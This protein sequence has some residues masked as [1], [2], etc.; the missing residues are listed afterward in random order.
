MKFIHF[1]IVPAL[2]I[3]VTSCS[4]VSVDADYDDHIAFSEYKTFGYYKDG[5][6][7]VQISDLDK[8]RIL[9]AI[10]YQLNAKGLIRSN[11]PDILVNIFTKTREEISVNQFNAGWGYGWGFGWNP[12]MWNPNVM[13]TTTTITE[14]F[15]YIDLIDAKKNELVWQGVGRG[16]IDTSMK[17]RERTINEFVYKIIAQYPPKIKKK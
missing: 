4:S 3:L 16:R 7:K 2:L 10:E 11:D 8:S 1:F 6:S 9:S 14:G 5:I 12:W 13:T 15:L 17:K